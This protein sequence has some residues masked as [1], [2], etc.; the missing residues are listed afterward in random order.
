MRVRF[1]FL[2]A[3]LLT[4]CAVRAQPDALR[5]ER[6]MGVEEHLPQS[7]VYEILEDQR[8]FLWFATR[9]G[10]GRWDGYT[11]RTWRREP[12]DTA[13]LPGNL[14][15]RIVEDAAGDLWAYTEQTDRSPTGIARLIGPDHETVQRYGHI[16]A[17]L[18]LGPDGMAW[19]VDAD[20]LYRFDA[21]RERFLS[22]RARISDADPSMNGGFA[23]RDGTLWISTQQGL[24]AYPPAGDG[25][26]ATGAAYLV[27]PDV[28]WGALNDPLFSPVDALAEAEDGTLW[29]AGIK[30]A[31]LDPTRRRMI[32]LPTPSPDPQGPGTGLVVSQI[33]PNGDALWLGTLDGVYRYDIA[34][35]AFARYSLRL[36][37]DIPTQNWVTALHHD[38]TGALW[39]G[40]VWGLHRALPF[41]NPFQLLA[42]NADDLNSLGS[43]IV[44]SVHED[45]HRTLWVGTLGGGLNRIDLD[46]RITR[47]R[48]DSGNPATIS[49]DW[50]WSLQSDSEHLWIGTSGGLDRIALDRPGRVERLRFGP[51][52]GPTPA[53]WGPSANG[54]H[55]DTDGTLWFGHAGGLNRLLPSGERRATR[56]P[57]DAA[58]N[59][60]RTVPGGAWVA[61]TDGLLRYNA[62][63]DAFQAYRHDP[64]DPTSL[65]DAAV[66]TIHLDRSG[67][68][69]VGTQSG[70][71]RYDAATNSFTHITSADGLPSDVVYA[72]LED[73]DSNLWVS[74]NRGLARLD[75]DALDAGVRAFTFADGVGN[76]E[77]NTNAA[78]QAQDGTMYFGG[79]RGVTVFDP[80]TIRANPYRPPVVLTALHR[81]TREGTETVRYLDAST[82]VEIP[83]QAY[84][85]TLEFA[86]LSFSNTERT[87]YAVQMEGWDDAWV[88]LGTQR[89]ATYTNLP[90]GR[91]TFRVRAANE[92]GVWDEEGLAVP[93]L[94]RPRVWQTWWFRALFV[95]LAVAMVAMA[96]WSASR[97]QYRR[98]LARLEARRALEAERARISRDMHDEVG[99]SLT[100]I[101][102]LSELARREL[103]R[104]GGDGAPSEPHALPGANR[105]ARIADT[106]R[107]TLDAIGE[108]VWALNPKNDRLP[109][110]V[111]YVREHAARY[112]DMASLNARLYFPTHVPDYPVTAEVR[113]NIF[114]IA[115]EALH[116]IVKHAQAETVVIRLDIE[117]QLLTLTIGDDGCGF[118]LPSGDGA[119]PLAADRFHGGNGL[120]N[121]QR[122]ATEVGGQLVTETTP[123]DGTTLRLTVPLSASSVVGA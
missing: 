77:F 45:T 61:T 25:M 82:P 14:V 117:E 40:T 110:L 93:L 58:I 41:T 100:E 19:L 71:N 10:L 97:R 114:L 89:Q 22:V 2:F 35:G 34:S 86:G 121:M 27:R 80:A 120:G 83:P 62:A 36:P 56:V 11:M 42:H 39:A 8:G 113:R 78:F 73:A 16:D 96:A 81:S 17:R 115:K 69:W 28:S 64:D 30:L 79:D 70:L 108:I 118:A 1:S 84:T 85:F 46:G 6:A 52:A 67:T 91:Y 21:T 119:A 72:I 23:T 37:G 38:R 102:F 60:V 48:H 13:S 104:T 105:L 57:G 31:R 75:P 4:A 122:R 94:V 18:L 50:I 98:E 51:E 44:L 33:V 103:E 99:A 5:F 68:L 90:P 123:G 7:S 49:H 59:A 116:N 43:G 3:L 20:S 53:G 106:S 54:L 47:Y 112:L 95:L 74:T 111:G 92:D 87:T 15:R 88:Q 76:V 109:A 63:E 24:E 55:L 66:V 29:I 32:T 12:F 9:E 26:P 107:A 65:S 101:T